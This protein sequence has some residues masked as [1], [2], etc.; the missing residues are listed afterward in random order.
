VEEKLKS[1]SIGYLRVAEE[2]HLSFPITG[3]APDQSP[4]S[5]KSH[6]S[7][8]SRV[9][10][11][12]TVDCLVDIIFPTSMSEFGVSVKTAARPTLPELAGGTNPHYSPTGSLS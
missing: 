12:D 6:D 9:V 3:R 7:P 2:F 1:T 11:V 5:Q 4:R 8:C 10:L